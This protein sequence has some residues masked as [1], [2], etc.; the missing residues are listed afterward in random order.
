MELSVANLISLLVAG[1]VEVTLPAQKHLSLASAGRV[2]DVKPA[3][4]R[5]HLAEFPNAFR[6]PAD[7]QAGEWRIPS[8]DIDAFVARRK[9]VAT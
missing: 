4:V 1:G 3:W 2:L 7:S 8:G 5:A 6:L 9:A